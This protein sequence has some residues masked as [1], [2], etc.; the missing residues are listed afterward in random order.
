VQQVIEETAE[1]QVGDPAEDVPGKDEF[2]GWGRVNAYDALASL[3][4]YIPVSGHITEDTT[5]YAGNVYMVESDLTVDTGVTLTIEAGTVVKYRRGYHD[6]WVYGILDCRGTEGNP[7]VFTSERDD[8]HGGDSN[9]DGTAT[10]AARGDWASLRLYSDGSVLEHCLFRYGGNSW[11]GDRCDAMVGCYD[12]S[13]RIA[14]CTIEHGETRGIYYRGG[15]VYGG[16]PEVEYNTITDCTG[17]GIYYIAD[18]NFASAPV[19]LYNVISGCTGNGILFE[20]PSSLLASPTIAHNTLVGAGANDGIEIRRAAPTGVVLSNTIH[21]FA[22]GIRLDDTSPTVS[23]NE[24]SGC[25]EPLH[26]VGTCLPIYS[27]I[28]SVIT[29]IRCWRWKVQWEQTLPGR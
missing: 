21:G 11:T 5:W 12:C 26:H 19:I 4:P 20:G 3:P 8:E 16:S 15:P 13:P 29:R 10:V 2:M 23:A 14:H 28:F 17:D 18:S 1:D 7:V 6:I 25:G 27:G 9:G 24:V 22:T